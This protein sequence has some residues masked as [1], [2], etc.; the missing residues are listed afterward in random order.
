MRVDAHWDATSLIAS[1]S[2]SENLLFVLF[3]TCSTP[4]GVSPKVKIGT[5]ARLSVLKPVLSSTSLLKRSSLYGSF[6][7]TDSPFLNTQPAM[8]DCSSILISRD[9][10]PRAT[11]VY[12]WW[13][14][15]SCRNKLPLSAPIVDV[16]CVIKYSKI[17]SKEDLLY[18]INFRSTITF[19]HGPRD[20]GIYTLLFYTN[21]LIICPILQG[22]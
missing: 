20:I 3:K 16:T 22:N 19:P 17:S 15:G 13:A 14:A 6:T 2:F 4:I 1:M 11:R 21:I 7:I 5:H 9:R 12:S 8:P 18:L 10:F